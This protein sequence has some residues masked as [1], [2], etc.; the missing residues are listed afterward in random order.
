MT[1]TASSTT[2]NRYYAGAIAYLGEDG[3]IDNVYTTGSIT[4]TATYYSYTGG[5]VGYSLGTIKNSYSTCTVVGKSSTLFATAG[6]LV[7]YLEGSIEDSYATGNVTATGGSN[8]YSK[9]GGLVGDK[10]TSA[11]ITNCYRADTQ[12]LIKYNSSDSMYN[13]DGTI[14]TIENIKKILNK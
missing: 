2:N 6:G 3:V 8:A 5:L 10:S 11:V 7:G 1:V 13:S 12:T 14:E 4:N 9:N